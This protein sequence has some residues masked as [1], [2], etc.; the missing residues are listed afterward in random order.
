MGA[1]LA[2]SVAIPLWMQVTSRRF[3]IAGH[4]ATSLLF[5]VFAFM[6]GLGMAILIIDSCGGAL[7]TAHWGVLFVLGGL[8]SS[9]VALM[10]YRVVRRI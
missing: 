5:G 7:Q 1:V 4:V 9:A 3:R 2:L 10:T 8:L 6:M